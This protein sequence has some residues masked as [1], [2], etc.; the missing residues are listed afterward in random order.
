MCRFVEY[1]GRGI[2]LR[3]LVEEPE[4]SLMV[5]SYRPRE[6]RSGVVNADG[7]GIGWY[8]PEIDETPCVFTS[9]LPIWSD[10]NLPQLGAKTRSGCIFAAVRSATPG[11]PYG[12]LHTQPFSHE[13]YL[14]MHNG[15]VSDF[16]RSLMRRLRQRLRDEYYSMIVGSSDS[17]HLFA[18]LLE[19]MVPKGESPGTP[20]QRLAE[21]MQAA[22][23]LM[24]RWATDLGLDAL[25][26]LAFTDGRASVTCRSSTTGDAPSL[27]VARDEPF[28]PEGVV[29]ASEPLFANGH[30]QEVPRGT[31]VVV[32]PDLGVRFI[33]TES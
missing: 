13:R 3:R 26:N 29:V 1:M 31:I 33:P 19:C 4:H 20:G 30:W 15:Y 16:R 2:F 10:T 5:Q 6:M 21:A 17:E 32:E 11:M 12:Q 8:Q 14:F 7:F 27:Y 28:F 24:H 25:L 18:L 9:G 22:L 23:Q